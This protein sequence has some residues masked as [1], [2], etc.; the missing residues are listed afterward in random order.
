MT[1]MNLTEELDRLHL[2][3]MLADYGLDWVMA[4]LADE[5]LKTT[6]YGRPMPSPGTITDVRRG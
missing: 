3:R 6:N 1:R 4:F 5:M 2:A